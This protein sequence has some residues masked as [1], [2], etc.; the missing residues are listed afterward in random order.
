MEEFKSA[1]NNM[2]GVKKETPAPAKVPTISPKKVDPR[3]VIRGLGE[4]QVVAQAQ[5]I[6]NPDMPS[7][8][9]APPANMQDVG[10]APAMAGPDS[11]Y[12]RIK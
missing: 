9:K 4:P 12:G 7:V 10:T 2:F 5:K 6:Y 1:L 8:P 3:D 11:G